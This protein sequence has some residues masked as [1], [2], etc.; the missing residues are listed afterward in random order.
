MK[1]KILIIF[2]LALSSTVFAVDIGGDLTLR[3]SWYMKDNIQKNQDNFHVL[4]FRI[5]Q[6]LN[7][8]IKFKAELKTRVYDYNLFSDFSK[9]S[10]SAQIINTTIT[11]WQLW[12]KMNNVLFQGL[13]VKLGKQYFE[14]GTAD[15]IHPTSVL[16]PD[17]W[18]N[19]F[20][21]GNK[22]PVS[23]LNLQYTKN[24]IQ[25]SVI[26][27]P[28][29]TPALFP[30]YFSLFDESAFVMPGTTL[31]T[32]TENLMFPEFNKSSEYAGKINFS[33][34]VIDFSFG[35]FSGFDYMPQIQTLTYSPVSMTIMNLEADYFFPQLEVYTFDFSTSVAGMGL[36]GEVGIYDYQTV[37]TILKTPFGDSQETALDGK[38]Y[39]TYVFGL[40]YNF[41]NGW[42]GNLQYSY[43]LPYVRGWQNFEDYILGTLKIPIGY[44]MNLNLA[45]MFGFKRGQEIK[46]N[47][48]YMLTQQ[49]DYDITDNATFS[50]YVSEIDAYGAMLFKSWE[51]YD[52]FGFELKYSF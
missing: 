26:W 2:F 23:A 25:A 8:N 40:D 9:L 38:P 30:R 42:Y 43:G 31:G 3:E 6:S 46:D 47:Y 24:F 5:G 37:N 51:K 16:N 14:W 7:Q 50:I 28:T 35:Y 1:Q 13:S 20:G 11:P 33:F 39:A 52:S 34:P 49:L 15:G 17:D 41:I 12:V 18:S 22:I 4:N 48:E 45:N 27:I 21:M 36:W 10:D 32:L 29:F 19:P 44:F